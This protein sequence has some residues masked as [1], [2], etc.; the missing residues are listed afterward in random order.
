MYRFY[1][2]FGNLGYVLR[3]GNNSIGRNK[4]RCFIHLREEYIGRIHTNIIV[5]NDRCCIELTV[6]HPIRLNGREFNMTTNGALVGI[7]LLIGDFITIYDYDFQLEEIV[8]T[9]SDLNDTDRE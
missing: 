3:E 5:N 9:N 4:S 8:I 1:L 7:D 6:G 2:K